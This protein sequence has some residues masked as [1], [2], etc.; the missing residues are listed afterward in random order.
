MAYTPNTWVVGDVITADKLNAL[1]QAVAENSQNSSYDAEIKIYHSDSS[2]DGY[3]LTIVSGTFASLYEM[4]QNGIEPYI[5][6]RVND[7]YDHVWTATSSVAI[8]SFDDNKIILFVKA[9]KAYST[10]TYS[11]EWFNYNYLFWNNANELFFD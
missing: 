8:Y 11:E 10:G 5:L 2:G 1:E 4:L 9:P 3:E 6:V 7:N